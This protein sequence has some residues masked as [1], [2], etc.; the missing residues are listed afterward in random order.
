MQSYYAILCHVLIAP[1]PCPVEDFSSTPSA[2][3]NGIPGKELEV[4]PQ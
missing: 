4:N 2:T 1:I 3:I